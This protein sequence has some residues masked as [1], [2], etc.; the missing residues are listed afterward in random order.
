MYTTHTI[1]DLLGPVEVLT[2][3]LERP[4]L[5]RAR[6]HVTQVADLV[7]ELYELARFDK[8][9]ACSICNAFRLGLGSD[10]HQ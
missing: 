7:G 4:I 2:T 6:R 9:G 5:W 3:A 1:H 10:C 8:W